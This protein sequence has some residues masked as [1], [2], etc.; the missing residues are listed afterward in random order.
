MLRVST[1]VKIEVN[2]MS[3][4]LRKKDNKQSTPRPLNEENADIKKPSDLDRSHQIVDKLLLGT[5]HGDE[6]MV[7][8][9]LTSS[10]DHI[11]Y[12]VARGNVEDYSGR[13]FQAI[14]A[15]Q[16][17]LWALDWHMWNLMLNVL[18][19]PHTK[20]L[21]NVKLDKLSDDARR[22]KSSKLSNK[23]IEAIRSELFEQYKEVVNRGLDYTITRYKRTQDKDGNYYLDHPRVVTVKGENHF[24]LRGP[25]FCLM[26]KENQLPFE[27]GKLYVELKNNEL[28]YRVLGLS[29]QLINDHIALADLHCNL[30]KLDAVE[31]LRPYFHRIINITADRDHT[32]PQELISAYLTYLYGH[33]EEH[34]NDERLIQQWCGGVGM[35]EREVPAVFAQEICRR[36]IL[37]DSR[38]S[39]YKEP[40]FPRTLIFDDW[41]NND[42]KTWF[43]LSKKSRLGLD[44]GI[45][46]FLDGRAAV[47][48]G[49]GQV[50]KTQKGRNFKAL[51]SLLAARVIDL[52]T[53]RDQLDPGQ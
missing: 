52:T 20:D 35:A 23:D 28:H 29:G 37:L 4:L 12:L 32:H 10:P 43:P 47:R 6:A 31:Q 49:G 33:E 42:I 26:P 53:L 45:Y 22:K 46:S 27:K 8:L 36:D 39:G 25:E 38:Q 41:A 40:F 15:F 17:T 34:W 51:S 24:D 2:I 7:Q 13:K 1:R 21:H 16:Y 14:S 3:K 30:I 44:F 18:N 48:R 19:K 5:T 11:R 9:L 50:W